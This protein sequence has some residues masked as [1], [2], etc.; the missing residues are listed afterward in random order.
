MEVSGQ[1]SKEVHKLTNIFPTVVHPRRVGRDFQK[2]AAAISEKGAYRAENGGPFLW[3]LKIGLPSLL[4]RLPFFQRT[5]KR[6]SERGGAP[7]CT[8]QSL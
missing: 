7:S 3:A 8:F 2:T 6:H 1:L 5:G 4:L